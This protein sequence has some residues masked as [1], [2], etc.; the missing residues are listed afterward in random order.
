MTNNANNIWDNFKINVAEMSRNEHF[1]YEI[2][3]LELPLQK[4]EVIR[5][6]KTVD[7]KQ[8]SL[9]RKDGKFTGKG[10]ITDGNNFDHIVHDFL[11]EYF[12]NNVKKTIVLRPYIRNEKKYLDL[13]EVGRMTTFQFICTRGDSDIFGSTDGGDE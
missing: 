7:C 10:I 13:V 8:I 6:I 1:E 5:S 4:N 9:Q 12:V 11:F 3:L 2:P